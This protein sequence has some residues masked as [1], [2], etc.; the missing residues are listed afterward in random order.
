MRECSEVGGAVQKLADA[1]SATNPVAGGQCV[2][3]FGCQHVW[4]EAGRDLEFTLAVVVTLKLVLEVTSQL[5]GGNTEQ[6]LDEVACQAN[7]LVGVVV[8]VVGVASFNGHFQDLTNDAAKV[9]GLLFAVG[10]LVAQVGE[11]LSVEE[12]VYTCFTVFLLLA[13]G[14]F[15][16]KPLVAFFGRDHFV[17]FVVVDFVDVGHDELERIGVASDGLEDV[18]VVFNTQRTHEEHDGDSGR[19]GGADLDHQHT[20]TALLNGQGFTHAVFL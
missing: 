4:A 17:L 10:D 9:D 13:C 7:A 20:V 5:T 1:G 12:L 16:L 6:V 3:D 14:E 19:T 2:H 11:Q 8:L 18:L 15:L